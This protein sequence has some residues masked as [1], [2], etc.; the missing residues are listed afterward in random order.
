MTYINDIIA[1]KNVLLIAL[2]TAFLVGFVYMIVL[3][4]AGGPI[5]YLSLLA[6]ILSS[7]G[8]GFMLFQTAQAMLDPETGK[9]KLA[10][11]EDRQ[12]YYQVGSYI[13]WGFSALILC[14]TICNWKNIKIGVAV[15]KC[16]A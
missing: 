5:I 7:A 13:V 10:Q 2:A 16:T 8:G 15:M 4:I 6:L 9:V 12:M 11:D 14:C 3:R 1:T